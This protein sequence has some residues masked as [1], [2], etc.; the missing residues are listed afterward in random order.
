[1][2][3]PENSSK[4]IRYAYRLKGLEEEWHDGDKN[5]SASY[6]NLPN[7]K[8]KLQIK[9]TNSDG[10]WMDNIRTLSINVLPTFWET[11][12]AWLLYVILFVLFTGSI[13]YVLFYIYRLR[14]QVD[15]EQQ[16]SNIK[17]RFFTDISH[18][19]RTPLTLISSPVN[20]VLENEDLSATAREHLTVVQNNAERMLRLMNQILDFRKIQNQKM[21]VLVEKTDLIPLLEKVMI[22][23]R[24]IAEE[25]KINFRLASELKSIYA[26]I[27]RDKFE[28]IFFNLISNAFKYTPAEKAITIEVTKQTDKVTISVVDE[29]IGI[30]PTKLRTL[31]QRFETLA[32][33]NMLQPSSGIGLSLVKEMVDMHHGTIKVT[34]EPEAGSRFMVTLPLQKEVFEQDSQVEFILNDSQSPTTH[35]DSSLQTEKRP[36]AEDKEDMENNA[37]PDTFTILVV[38]DNEELKAFLKNILSEN[39]TVITAPNGKEGLQHAVDNIPDLIIS[40]VMM[41]VMDGLEMIRKI[42]ENNNI[43][44]IPIIVLSAKASLDDRI[45]GLEQGIDDYITKPF[46]A[47]YLK[48]RIASLLRQR[49]SLQE[50][51]MAKLTE[52]KE[53]AVA[54]A[55]TPSQP[56][57]TPYDEQ[58]MQKVMEFIEEQ[59]DNAE[60]TI[61]EF[62]EHLMLS[63]TIFYRKLKS[64]IGLTP[65]DFIREVRIKRAAQLIDSGEYNFSQVAYMTGFNDPKYFSKCFKKVVGITPS[66]YKEKNK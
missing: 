59:M 43:C 20:E 64:I 34:S 15:I 46:S 65:V 49:K 45:A 4:E 36:E 10:V 1:M 22:N 5:R 55:L 58:F 2:H 52:G 16:L 31:F 26:W 62:A 32:Q 14:H 48:T 47:T 54:E 27:D 17:L 24:L 50:I 60:L 30:E 63:R 51:Y 19:L 23:F 25:K 18:E 6:I 40:D 37:A 66:E 42:K 21:K 57:I 7:G 35:P 39:Y 12:W 13:V 9:S 8:Y 3:S 53:I 38:E 29:G 41:P 33:Q 11:G 61:D 56:Q 44:H 28:K